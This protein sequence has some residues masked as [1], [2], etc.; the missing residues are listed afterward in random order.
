MSE[1]PDMLQDLFDKQMSLNQRIGVNPRDMTEDEQVK[2]ILNYTRAASQEMAELIDSV[3]WKWWA[4]YQEFDVQNAKVEVVD[5]FHFIISLAQ[6]LGMDAQDVHNL[7]NQKNKLNFKRQDDGYA[8]KDENDNR[9]L[10]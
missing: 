4:K 5:L 7:Y 9:G 2:W 6:V 1:Q 3:P 8:V 10:E